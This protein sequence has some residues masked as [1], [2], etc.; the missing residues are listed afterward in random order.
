MKSPVENRRAPD[1]QKAEA[2]LDP[3]IIA[4]AK[5]TGLYPVSK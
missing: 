4:A 2:C 1:R 3:G 5:R